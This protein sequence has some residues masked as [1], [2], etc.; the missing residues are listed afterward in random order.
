MSKYLGRSS[1]WH[2]GRGSW[3]GNIPKELNIKANLHESK[4]HDNVSDEA[5]TSEPLCRLRKPILHCSC[6]TFAYMDVSLMSIH[7]IL[8]HRS[9][10]KFTF[11]WSHFV[12]DD[13]VFPSFNRASSAQ[14]G[15][16]WYRLRA[17]QLP[18]K[19]TNWTLSLETHQ[20]SFWQN[21]LLRR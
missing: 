6:P 11:Q 10:L 4:V 1:N 3:L 15:G 16:Q 21:L 8:L 17:P 20:V 18:S 13:S 5:E 2:V 14:S 7:Q 19:E 9:L 12:L